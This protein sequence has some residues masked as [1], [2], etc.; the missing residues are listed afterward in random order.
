MPSTRRFTKT[1]VAFAALLLGFVGAALAGSSARAAGEVCEGSGASLGWNSVSY[2]S[3]LSRCEVIFNAQDSGTTQV[4]SNMKLPSWVT[5]F[6]LLMVGGGGSGAADT[7]TLQGGGGGGGGAIYEQTVN[8]ASGTALTIGVGGGTQASY[9]FSQQ[10]YVGQNGFDSY[11]SFVQGATNYQARANGGSAPNSWSVNQGG[12]GGTTSSTNLWP[13]FTYSTDGR[14]G[15]DTSAVQGLSKSGF[16]D[17]LGSGGGG[18]AGSDDVGMRLQGYGAGGGGISIGN[19]DNPTCNRFDDY[20]NPC[21]G[22]AGVVRILYQA[23]NYNPVSWS[24]FPTLSGP[25]V[26]G[27]ALTAENYYYEGADNAGGAAPNQAIQWFRCSGAQVSGPSSATGCAAISGA[28]SASYTPTGADL[29]YK[30]QARV[31]LSNSGLLLPSNTSNT[32]TIVGY[33]ETQVV[34]NTPGAPTLSAVTIQSPTRAKLTIT[35]GTNWGESL[36]YGFKDFGANIT[37][38]GSL[39]GSDLSFTGLTPG[40]TYTVKA[41]QQNSAGTTYSSGQ[42]SFTMPAAVVMTTQGAITGDVRVGSTLTYTPSQWVGGAAVTSTA[43]WFSCTYAANPLTATSPETDVS[44]WTTLCTSLGAVSAVGTSLTLTSTHNGKYIMVKEVAVDG[45]TT[46]YS[47]INTATAV[48]S[49]PGTVTD[50]VGTSPAARDFALTF[51]APAAGASAITGYRFEYQTAA[52]GY[53]TTVGPVTSGFTTNVSGGVVTMTYPNWLLAYY[54]GTFKFRV[55]VQNSSGWSVASAFS[56]PVTILAAANISGTPTISGTATVGSTLT[57]SESAISTSG[58]PAPTL[59]RSWWACSSNTVDANMTGCSVISG[60]SGTTYVV[61]TEAGQKHIV[62]RLTSQNTTGGTVNSAYAKSAAT[63]LVPGT[64]GAVTGIAATVQSAATVSVAYTLPSIVGAGPVTGVE[65]RVASGPL[66]AYPAG[67]T[68]APNLSGALNLTGLTS[69]TDYKIQLRA[70]NLIG[71]GSGAEISSAFTTFGASTLGSAPTISGLARVGQVITA[72]EPLGMFVGN[73]T[74]TISARSWMRCPAALSAGDSVSQCST[75]SG[76]TSLSYTVVAADTS[77][78]LVYLATGTN[79]EGQAVATSASTAIIA[80]VPAIPSIATASLNGSG[81][82]SISVTPGLLNN[83]ALTNVEYEINASGNWVSTSS[84]NLVVTVSG[85]TNG[86]VNAIRVRLSNAVGT[87]AASQAFDVTPLASAPTPTGARAD[88]AIALS[89]SALAGATGYSVEISTQSNAG[90]TAA[91]NGCGNLTGTACTISGLT[92]GQDYYL[93]LFA[94]NSFGTSAASTVVGPIRPLSRVTTLDGLEVRTRSGVS[95]NQLLAALS[96]SFAT[97]TRNYSMAVSTS[98]QFLTVTPTRGLA[99]QAILVNGTAVNSGSASANIPLSIGANTVT[100]TVQ[101]V[102][103]VSDSN[104]TALGSYVITVTRAEPDMSG[105]TSLTS[106]S[107][108][109]LPAPVAFSS[110]G[111]TGVTNANVSA[112]NSAIAGLPAT[113]VDT[114]AEL[115]V[116]V[117]AYLAIIAQSNGGSPSQAP[118]AASYVALGASEAGS[119]NAGQVSY[120]NTLIGLQSTGEVA[121]V[122]T[123][124]TLVATVS[125]LYALAAGTQQ[126]A[127]TVDDLAVMGVTGVTS[128]NLQAVLAAIAATADDGSGINSLAEVQALVNAVKATAV[129]SITAGVVGS[130]APALQDYAQAGV[131]GVTSSTLS[132][133]TAILAA[134]PNG[135]KDSTVEIQAIVDAFRFIVSQTSSGSSAEVLDSAAALGLSNPQSGP[136][137]ALYASIG[138]SGPAALSSDALALLNN[139]L[140]NLSVAQIDS[141]A[142]LNALAASVTLIQSNVASATIADFERLGFQGLTADNLAVVRSTLASLGASA[143]NTFAEIQAVI[144]NSRTAA[145]ATLFANSGGATVALP[146]VQDLKTMGVTGVTSSNLL[147]LADAM[148]AAATAANPPGSWVATPSAV[149]ALL[150]A[151]QAAQLSTISTY[152]G[153]GAAPVVSDYSALGVVGVKA[154]NVAA[155]NQ[156]VARLPMSLTDSSIELQSVVNAYSSVLNAAVTGLASR[157]SLADLLALGVT[158][159]DSSNFAAVA[160]AIALAQVGAVDTWVELQAVVTTA[161]ASISTSV[162]GVLGFIANSATAPSVATY[163]AAGIVGVSPDNKAIIELILAEANPA[164]STVAEIQALVNSAI[165]APLQRIAGVSAGST[166]TVRV[167]DFLQSGISGVT[168]TNASAVTAILAQLPAA[169]RDSLTEIQKIVDAFNMVAAGAQGG[170]NVASSAPKP[171]ISDFALLGID[172]GP[173]AEDLESFEFLL[174]TLAKLPQAAVASVDTLQERVDIIANVL[175]VASRKAPLVPL[176]AEA[177]NSIGFAG[178]TTANIAAVVAELGEGEAGIAGLPSIEAA[179]T[180]Y[181]APAA[182]TVAPRVVAEAPRVPIEPAKPIEQPGEA[183]NPP[184]APTAPTGAMPKPETITFSAGSTALSAAAKRVVKTQVAQIVKSNAKAVTVTVKASLPKNASKAWTAQVLNAAKARA[185][186]VYKV[187]STE[188]KALKSKTKAVVKVVTTTAQNVRTVTIAGT[189]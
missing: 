97:A 21:E 22:R 182:P 67:W 180:K 54:T 156:I 128:A 8:I 2:N 155:I 30:L 146:T 126:A 157:I 133:L 20:S 82:A 31:T 163:E 121:N 153:S 118:N 37:R 185:N 186:V 59:S 56:E 9:N 75:I 112:V 87:S 18:G 79:S 45:Y 46:T 77:S 125:N 96:P 139:T 187:V 93:K 3:A 110:I 130:N 13:D 58:N 70:G 143:K 78:Y 1:R 43:T 173:M 172:L 10:G 73:P 145:L 111:V 189:K 106:S 49:V 95:A 28:T 176:T 162:N 11:I 83:S 89:W 158:G 171:T 91:A 60:Q 74:P 14:S 47:R 23:V 33:S 148:Q 84:A 42:L 161:V 48:Q 117:D 177:L 44:G 62:Y 115:Q 114:P 25:A 26:V 104:S 100:V 68:A 136:T 168:S 19:Y 55:S 57:A 24:N 29:N 15:S 166:T 88:S 152:S 142:E 66:F 188:L 167:A 135:S 109:A 63:A 41:Y 69:N 122:A 17:R 34:M 50:L 40:T 164:P 98:A 132:S 174:A 149:Q 61:G 32:T 175:R 141:A 134:L 181:S 99:G 94:T 120:L 4:Y 116:V 86:Q 129:V 52:N 64:P 170:A 140:A 127:L 159:V 12:S 131:V 76:A 123:I 36:T 35:A 184:K 80:N 183:T 108:S 147:A 53:G 137:A 51:T 151:L 81:S 7:S 138:A 154:G 103:R 16:S 38:V 144:D 169:Q 5:N 165:A 113:F 71:F 85:L 105:F 27:T 65:Y 160:K 150:N 102:E 72:T 39:S 101:S 119:F 179:A 90:F 92:N 107:G 178:V 124:K 6:D